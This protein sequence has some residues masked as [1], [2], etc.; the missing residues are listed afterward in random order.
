MANRFELSMIG[1]AAFAFS[2]APRWNPKGKELFYRSGDK[3]MVVVVTTSPGFS[4]SR[5][6]L[7]YQGPAGVPS[8]D[9]QRFL[10][11]QAV[12]AERPPT[13]I[14]VLLNWS[15]EVKRRAPTGVR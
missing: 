2:P 6:R 9:G 10:T 3:T 1:L 5:P 8:P 13:Q 12:E 4:G 15:K 7:L 11:V 14:S